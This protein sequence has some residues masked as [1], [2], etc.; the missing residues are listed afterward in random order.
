MELDKRIKEG[1]KPLTCFDVEEAKA[2][3]GKECYQTDDVT[4]FANV[5]TLTK[6]T[7]VSIDEGDVRP[8]KLESNRNWH[9]SSIFILPCEWVEE[10]KKYRPYTVMEFI[11]YYPIGSHLHFRPK[12]DT[13]EMHRLIAGYNDCKN[14][15]GSLFICGAMYSMFE[16]YDNYEIFKDGEWQ[17]FGIKE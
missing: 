13:M 7:L 9:Y 8:Y 12:N 6:A 10:E 2:F 16:L 1:K 3:L 11:K 14:G 5:D 4:G 17:P 15:A